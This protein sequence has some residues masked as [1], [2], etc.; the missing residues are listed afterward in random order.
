MTDDSFLKDPEYLFTLLT[1]IV[2]KHG[3][4]L[5]M[6]EEDFL[7]VTTQDLVGLFVDPKNNEITLKVLNTGASIEEIL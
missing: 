3:G 5:T 2:K 1:A 4:E 6:T 7:C